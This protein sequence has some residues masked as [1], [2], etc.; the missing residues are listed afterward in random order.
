M[1]KLIYSVIMM[2]ER[3]SGDT[4]FEE[5][6]G[7]IIMVPFM[8]NVLVVF[9][10]LGC[11]YFIKIMYKPVC[12]LEE[13]IHEKEHAEFIQSLAQKNNKDEKLIED[14]EITEDQLFNKN[15]NPFITG[16]EKKED[17]EDEEINIQKNI[18]I[19]NFC[20]Y[21]LGYSLEENSL[22]I[23]QSNTLN[24]LI[25]LINFIN[26]GNNN[27]NNVNENEE[28]ILSNVYEH[29]KVYFD[30]KN[31]NKLSNSKNDEDM[32]KK[33]H[34]M[35]NS[36]EDLNLE[37]NKKDNEIKLSNKN[38]AIQN[39][40][41]NSLNNSTFKLSKTMKINLRK[42]KVLFKES[43]EIV[44]EFEEDKDIPWIREEDC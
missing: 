36:R 27:I 43:K 40:N 31:N 28:K 11:T 20:K 4:S 17:N 18:F 3:S 13:Y 9:F 35:I 21:S 29:L 23:N 6:Y 24:K 33:I 16:R 7:N 25:K 10:R 30:N 2:I 39:F 41:F 1:G 8:L 12:S 14:E 22:D 32:F 15:N 44:D 42:S 34:K 38:S 37:E 26:I 5:S 19:R